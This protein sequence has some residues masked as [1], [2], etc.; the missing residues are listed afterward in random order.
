MLVKNPKKTNIDW[1]PH[2]KDTGP[3][4]LHKNDLHTIDPLTLPPNSLSVHGGI[5]VKGLV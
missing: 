3:S 2:P 4:N 5:L 1:S